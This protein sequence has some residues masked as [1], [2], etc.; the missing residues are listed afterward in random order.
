MMAGKAGE[1]LCINWNEFGSN[2]C[3]T[4]QGLRKD[5]DFADVRLACED[6]QDISCH[7]V[8]LSS[9]SPVFTGIFK[10]LK[11]PNPVVFLKGIESKFL[12][13]ILDFIYFGEVKVPQDDLTKF[14]L[15]ANELK[16]KGLH[17]IKTKSVDNKTFLESKNIVNDSI[18]ENMNASYEN[19][20]LEV[21]EECLSEQ[22]QD[23][24]AFPQSYMNDSPYTESHFQTDGGFAPP[25]PVN[26]K[27]LNKQIDEYIT[28]VEGEYV[29]TICGKTSPKARKMVMRD[30]VESHLKLTE[31][32]CE[33][34]GKL[35]G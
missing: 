2:L 16:I 18:K 30:H 24:I 12:E 6:L 23:N 34:C 10:N 22:G 20:V 29:C 9:C 1:Q 17:D 35:F 25:P 19:G 15:L 28:T 21:P 13:L 7:K 8:I 5:S 3:T 31:H 32:P 33:I 26:I 14:L 4:F 27:E 11:N